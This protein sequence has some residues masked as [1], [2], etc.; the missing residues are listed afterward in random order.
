MYAC[1][2]GPVG[3]DIKEVCREAVVRI[4]HERASAL[5]SGL[6]VLDSI[7]H[8]YS[9]AS[10]TG[11]SSSES[12]EVDVNTA[13]RPVTLRD[14]KLSMLK[15]KSSVNDN[16]KEMQKVV[17]WNNKYGEIKRKKRQSFSQTTSIYV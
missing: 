12:N 5:E 8:S 4:A 3:S 6:E 9:N 17:E 14:F 10:T 7:S 11:L 1:Y 2:D 15:L 13:L 16:G